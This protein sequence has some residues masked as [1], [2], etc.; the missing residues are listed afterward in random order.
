MA[1][2]MTF[3]NKLSFHFSVNVFTLLIYNWPKSISLLITLGYMN[4]ASKRQSKITP[5]ERPNFTDSCGR[6]G[7][8]EIQQCN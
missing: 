8:F 3:Y 1:V 4:W 6:I 2:W 5:T 7:N